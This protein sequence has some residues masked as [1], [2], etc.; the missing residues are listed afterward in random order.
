MHICLSDCNGGSDDALVLQSES[1][2]PHNRGKQNSSPSIHNFFPVPQY[3]R[4]QRTSD[5]KLPQKCVHLRLL[6]KWPNFLYG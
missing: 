5:R 4:G 3:L 2:Q 1:S 6:C